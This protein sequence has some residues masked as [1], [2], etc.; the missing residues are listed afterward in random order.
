MRPVYAFPPSACL[1]WKRDLELLSVT[2]N[3]WTSLYT[4]VQ[5]NFSMLVKISKKYWIPRIIKIMQ[6]MR[7]IHMQKCSQK[8][9]RQ[10]TMGRFLTPPHFV[11][12]KGHVS[13][14]WK[15]PFSPSLAMIQCG[16]IMSWPCPSLWARIWHSPSSFLVFI[17]NHMVGNMLLV[18][19]GHLLR[20]CPFSRSCQ[21]SAADG[22]GVLVRQHWCCTSTTQWY[23]KQW[24]VTNIFLAKHSIVR[25]AMRE[26]NSDAARLN[27]Q[28]QEDHWVAKILI[29]KKTPKT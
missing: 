19:L 20:L 11:P 27:T 1:Q 29:L 21:A 17:A 12:P 26:I 24:C 14:S 16:I 4:S 2:T 13:P 5:F 25:V 7:M 10:W 9:P 18:R 15:S 8:T 28:V 22:G 23:P 6:K 3:F